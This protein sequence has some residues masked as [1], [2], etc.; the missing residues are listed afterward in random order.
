MLHMSDRDQSW[1]IYWGSAAQFFL[2][3]ADHEN[4]GIC[5]YHEELSN[6][7][8]QNNQEAQK[9]SLKAADFRQTLDLLI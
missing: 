1:N 9:N 8:A 4:W 3:Q 2:A 6:K 5:L 7:T